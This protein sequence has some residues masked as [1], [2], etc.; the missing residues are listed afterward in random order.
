MTN[1]FKCPR[2]HGK[3]VIKMYVGIEQGVCFACNGH[4]TVE[5][6]DE[7]VLPSNKFEYVLDSSNSFIFYIFKYNDNTGY[8]YQMVDPITLNKYPTH[9]YANL[10]ELQDKFLS[11]LLT[12]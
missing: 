12:L 8:T 10:E 9:T 7:Y 6:P 3:G 4:K 1:T 2:C 11:V 5:L